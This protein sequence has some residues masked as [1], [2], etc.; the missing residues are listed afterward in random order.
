MLKKYLIYHNKCIFI[1]IKLSQYGILNN[2]SIPVR[3]NVRRLHK[4]QLNVTISF[5]KNMRQKNVK[6]ILIKFNSY[7]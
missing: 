4:N 7:Y 5:N 6:T 3:Y 1:V 2:K